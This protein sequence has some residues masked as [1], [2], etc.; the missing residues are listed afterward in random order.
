M[1]EEQS[2]VKKTESALD[3]LL[4]LWH[5]RKLVCVIVLVVIILPGGFTL[6]Q[7]LVTVPKLKTQI[8]TLKS[9]KQKAE[10]ERDKA[11]LQLAPFLATAK[12]SF[13]DAPPDK[14]LELLLNRMEQAVSEVQNAARRIGRDR[15]LSDYLI[16]KVV[17]K[18]KLQ[19]KMTVEI[20]TVLGD[21][22]GFALAK[23]LETVF[24]QA[25]WPITEG[26]ISQAVFSAPQKG[27]RFVFPQEQTPSQSVQ[28]PFLEI[29]DAIG[30]E[31]KLYIDPNQPN[32]NL[33]IVVGSR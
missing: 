21:T 20:T 16:K 14:R 32:D 5:R 24:R 11:E 18:L 33:K 19:P 27:C 3:D 17:T 7:Q 26:G 15:V 8:S 22:D 23:Q 2:I 28:E 12:A 1:N 10:R 30:Q 6:Y 29:L 9:G 25:G 31:K 13:P 4:D